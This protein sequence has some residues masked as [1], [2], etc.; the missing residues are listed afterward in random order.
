MGILEAQQG[1]ALPQRGADLHQL[2]VERDRGGLAAPI[3]QRLQLGLSVRE[4][5]EYQLTQNGFGAGIDL[6]GQ[7]VPEDRPLIF[8]GD[9]G[10]QRGLA[11][12]RR[13]L[14]L[15]VAAGVPWLRGCPAG[16][17]RG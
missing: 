17:G 8:A 12:A 14:R 2:L 5:E 13:A 1:G 7:C 4:E 10:S 11:R 16:R 3:N 9:G 15:P 6:G